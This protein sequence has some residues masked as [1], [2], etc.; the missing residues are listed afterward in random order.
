MKPKERNDY[1]GL[2]P[3][4]HKEPMIY[5]L[6]RQHWAVCEEHRVCW[7]VGENLFDSWRHETPED[8]RKNYWLVQQCEIV[9]A[10]HWPMKCVQCGREEFW[11]E[12]W[13]NHPF[14]LCPRCAPD[15][16][17]QPFEF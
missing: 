13:L 15:W 3:V 2:C 12:G 16:P 17:E 4:C 10:Y 8:W 1:F 7:N 11:K 5:N 6:Q 9:E 14:E